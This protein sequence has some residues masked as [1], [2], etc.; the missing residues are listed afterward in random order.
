M[1]DPK[2]TARDYSRA[3][4]R[5][6]RPSRPWN[7]WMAD[8]IVDGIVGVGIVVL[9]VLAFAFTKFARGAE[10]DR[11]RNAR[12]VLALADSGKSIDA[13]DRDARVALAF[14]PH[15]VHPVVIYTAPPPKAKPV[16]PCGDNCKCAPGVCPACPSTLKKDI[17]KVRDSVVRVRRGNASGSGTVIWSEDGRS[18]VLT[19]AHVVAAGDGDVTVRGEGKTHAARILG[20]DDSADLAALLVTAELPAVAVSDADPAAGSEVLM[21]GLTSIWSAGKIGRG[22]QLEGRDV[23]ELSYESDYGDSGAGVFLRGELCGVH[24]G[25]VGSTPTAA[26]VPYCTSAKP[27]RAFLAKLFRRD[28]GKTVLV[29]IPKPMPAKIVPPAERRVV[30]YRCM[31]VDG[32]KVCVPIYEP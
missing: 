18:V 17:A 27:V 20:R 14:A 11:D 31:I 1:V 6:R 7:D 12:A 13:R 30:G 24:C 22:Y 16:C 25:K 19:A 23:W 4:L 2:K 15:T 8:G 32:R 10:P 9:I 29:E 21:V 26:G 5:D 3:Y 28:G